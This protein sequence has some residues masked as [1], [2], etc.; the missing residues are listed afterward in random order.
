MRRLEIIR[1]I[2]LCCLC[3]LVLIIGFGAM[4]ASSVQA[5]GSVT[6]CRNYGPG[7]G[8]FQ[9]ALADGGTIIF[10]CSGKIVVPEIVIRA[11][12][13]I[14]A[15]GQNV[16]LSG[17]NANRVFT[18]D[19]STGSELEIVNLTIT[20]GIADNGGGIA[21]LSDGWKSGILI[22]KNTT[23]YR[24]NAIENGGGLF[25]TIGTLI[26]DNCIISE[27][28]ANA[29]GGGIYNYY[30]AT[31]DL[32]D[33]TISDNQAIGSGGGIYSWNISNATVS[34]STISGNRANTGGG[35]FNGLNHLYY[36]GGWITLTNSTV[37]GNTAVI[38]G[39]AIHNDNYGT[40][41]LNNSTI[42]YNIA[43]EGGGIHNSLFS[44]TFPTNTIIAN[45]NGGNCSPSWMNYIWDQGY[46]L[47]DDNTC[48]LPTSTMPLNLGP[49]TD[50]GGPT[51]IH[52]LLSGS[53]AIDTGDCSNDTVKTDQRGVARP[54]GS[55]CD[56]GSFEFGASTSDEISFW[57]KKG[58]N[59]GLVTIIIRGNGL[60]N[61]AIVRLVK[62]NVVI[63]EGQYTTV[64][65]KT[66][67][68][69]TFDLLDKAPGD[70][71]I[72]VLNPDGTIISASESFVVEEGGESNLWIDIIGRDTSRTDRIQNISI[73]YGNSGNVDAK[74]VLLWLNIPKGLSW[75]LNLNP[76]TVTPPYTE[77]LGTVDWSQYPYY[78]ETEEQ[79]MI[80]ILV[81]N[82]S[83]GSLGTAEI[84][85]SSPSQASFELEANISKSMFKPTFEMTPS[86][87]ILLA[88]GKD[89][90]DHNAYWESTNEAHKRYWDV[91]MDGDL[92]EADR[93][94]REEIFPATEAFVWAVYLKIA[95]D[96]LIAA[97]TKA[98]KILTEGFDGLFEEALKK[99]QSE[100]SKELESYLFELWDSIIR[101]TKKHRQE[102]N[103]K[104][105]IQFIG[106]IDPNDKIGPKGASESHY[107]NSGKHLS[108][109][110]FFENKETA[111]ASAQAV[112]IMDKLDLTK[113]DI[114]SF[115]F[116]AIKFSEHSVFPP[117]YSTTFIE[118]VDLRPKNELIVR[119]NA[120]LDQITG[121]VIW[122]FTSIDPATGQAPKDPLAGFFPPNINPP[123]GEG[124][125]LY[126]VMTKT[127][128]PTGSEIRNQASIVFDTNEPIDTPEWL[129]TID[130]N[131]PQSQVSELTAT[132][133]SPD[134]QIEWFGTDIGAG[135]KDYTIFVSE[136]GGPFATWR[137][138]TAET[139]ATFTGQNGKTYEFYSVARDHTGNVE[140]V[141]G[142][143]DTNTN[144]AFNQS[145]VAVCKGV[146]L[147]KDPGVC[148]AVPDT[149]EIGTQ[150]NA[151]SY[152]PDGGTINLTVSPPGPYNIG[153]N[154]VTLTVTDDKGVSN[155]CIATVSVVDLE[156]PV[157]KSLIATPNTLSPPNH[158][159]KSVSVKVNSSDNCDTNSLCKIISVE[160]NEPENGT[161]DGDTAPD[162]Q[163]TGDLTVNLRSERAGNGS[164]RT[165]A[166][167]VEC[168]DASANRSIKDVI[169]TVP[170][171][172]GK[173]K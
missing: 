103:S 160:S 167:N 135:V 74:G 44:G 52:A 116:G 145:P 104:L 23:V 72:E 5:A 166:I 61:G 125:V 168:I 109:E 9:E 132:Q 97:P 150:V 64:T 54:Q 122:R 26:L 143:P 87:W 146:A 55:A 140:V 130:N 124:S 88:L 62:E 114:N 68:K 117:P 27:N 165:Y 4:G 159:M 84:Q 96:V 147:L 21:N 127:G 142:T 106:S 25:N 39:G 163:I 58:G 128:L 24:N 90:I 133:T 13:K 137:Q 151:G 102:W 48:S 18:L 107:I 112:I 77:G 1:S 47:S 42:A 76:E 31:L 82:I 172:N 162:W 149:V 78:L 118:E 94:K 7:E 119:I 56:I 93:I 134:F 171:D 126:T 105:T 170:H 59:S 41:N 11:N 65:N 14:D 3:V 83:S 148:F 51:L 101:F 111:T 57:P 136:N 123:E 32:K 154:A 91:F 86:D 28:T 98:T 33:T 22:L 36:G 85:I 115:S 164:G 49:L 139:S 110:I 53:P 8:T 75:N 108:Y 161:G 113:L 43:N 81:P 92:I 156:P 153:D 15:T 10:E 6:D 71:T 121:F 67:I 152:D 69:T 45:N 46:N 20:E 131:K 99:W 70:F 34:N 66:L 144:I 40:V 73:V 35:I 19:G 50:N 37:S 60:Q 89:S 12:T 158:K 16:I 29:Q 95:R 155:Q 129:N 100:L 120:S 80:P 173:K 157:I 2:V 79:T 63:L 38:V 138:N 17:N 169:V 30:F 141:P